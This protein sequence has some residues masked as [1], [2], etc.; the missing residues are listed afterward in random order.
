MNKLVGLLFFLTP[1]VLN[2]QILQSIS[3]GYDL[4]IPSKNFATSSKLATGGSLQYQAKFNGPLGVQVHIGYSHFTNKAVSDEYVDFLPVRIGFIYFL[5]QDIIF[6]SAD[7]GVSRYS[8]SSGTKQNGFTFGFGPG[9][10]LYFNPTSKQFVQF[11]AYYNLHH[12]YS[13]YTGGYNY[14]WFNIRAA[15]GI[16]FSKRHIAK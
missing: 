1:I 10:K 16:S 5:Y 7:G 15:Y 14:T 11:S 6:V 2:S 4:G 13:K 12:F 3:L 8:A 9:Y